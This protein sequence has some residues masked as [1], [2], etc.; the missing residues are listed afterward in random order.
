MA[1]IE[2]AA[3]FYLGKEYNLQKS[4]L[5]SDE[6]LMYDA[7][8]LT[9]HA[10][11]I[12]M[13]G[14]GKTGLGSI[15]LEEAAL[16]GIP[17]IVIDPKGDM[18]NLLLA[19]P[20]L[21][22]SDFEPW[23]N[24]DDARRKDMSTLEY[25]ESM[26]SLWR[27]G[28]AEWGQDGDRIRRMKE[29]AEFAIYTPGS[30]AGLQVSMLSS[31][32]APSLS[33]DDDEETLREIISGT[34]SGLLGLAGIQA[35]PVQSREHILLSHIFEHAWRQGQDLDLTGLIEAIQRPP[36]KKLG[37]FDV[38]TFYPEKDRFGL[39]M[40]L[41]RVVASPSFENWLEGAPL[42]VGQLTRTSSGKARVSVFYIAHLNEAE[43]VF[44]VTM[45]LQQVLSWMRQLS[46]TTSLRCMLYFDEVFGYFPPYPANP[47]SKQPLLS[48]LKTARAFGVG[49]VL[50]TQNPVDLDY[51]GL[52]NA[53]TWFIGKLQTDRDKARLLEGLEGVVA[54]AG[55]MLD[56]CYL[57][58]LTSSLDS[59]VFILHNVHEDQPVL[60]KTRWALSYLRGPMTRRQ[61]RAL[62]EPLRSQLEP[63]AQAAPSLAPTH[64]TMTPGQ[65]SAPTP[66]PSGPSEAKPDIPEGYSRIQPRMD[67]R[68]PQYYLSARTSDRQAEREFLTQER[69]N[70]QV[71]ANYLAYEPYLFGQVSVLYSDSKRTR[72]KGEDLAY[73][74]PL[75]DAHAFVD[76]EEHL[77]DAVSA[78]D[79]DSES[80]G[81]A[82]YGAV[83]SSMT[84]TPPY[85]R[86]KQDLADNIYRQRSYSVW[87]HPQ[88]GLLSEVDEDQERFKARCGEAAREKLDK[89]LEK[90]RQKYEN[91]LDRLQERLAREERE[92]EK[93]RDEHEGR[94]REELLSAGESVLSLVLGRRRSSA[95]SQAS[96]KRRMT[97]KARAD[98]GESEE[99][100]EDLQKEIQELL[101]EREASLAALGNEWTDVADAIQETPLRPKKTDIRVEA[102]GLCWVPHW[103]FTYRDARGNL[104]DSIVPALRLAGRDD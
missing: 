64:A 34:V 76:W 67:A 62:M 39:A 84:T 43:R 45:L 72:T 17:A 41:N 69:G 97:Q 95:L 58:R 71:E 25:S 75:P 16:D 40:A 32:K 4:E 91:S 60:F 24:P 74:L 77:A 104:L 15:L 78:T 87:R 94:K 20:D 42:D 86:Y 50:T 36:I 33:W 3:A 14:S 13:T 93:D 82:L 66:Q 2:R 8:D 5:A 89:E 100:I 35:D 10:I 27:K 85:T 80:Y 92:L 26:A 7:R 22:A 68:V 90:T 56:R 6:P 101:A 57:D 11:C 70:I 79:M 54:E 31:L 19:F 52:T 47:P 21:L 81:D 88:L 55:T 61:I 12:G 49:V 28:L 48:L 83:D 44:F 103:V 18:T 99:V 30:D 9:T 37:V 1:G 51:K 63:A 29:Q 46:G 23:V 96:R 102:L 65:A 59:R 73:L 98:I 53:G 38:E